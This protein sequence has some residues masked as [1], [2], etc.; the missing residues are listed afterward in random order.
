M[1]DRVFGDWL[2]DRVFCEWLG[3]R[4]LVGVNGRSRFVCVDWAITFLW[5]MIGRSRFL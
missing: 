4:V 2:G 1:G 3:D 5:G